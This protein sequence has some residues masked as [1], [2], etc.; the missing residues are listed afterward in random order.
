MRKLLYIFVT[1]IVLCNLSCKEDTEQLPLFDF[2]S[3]TFD[4]PFV[5][6]LSSRPE[7]LVKS[8]EYP[9]FSW[10][11]SDTVTF[12][13]DLE[14]EFNE[15]CIRSKSFV[16]LHIVDTLF[17]AYNGI[18]I[19]YNNQT[20]QNNSFTITADSLIKSGKINITISP[21]LKDTIL[22][23]FII[24]EGNAIDTANDVDLQNSN[25][26]IAT[27]TGKQKLGWP[28][29][30]WLI[31][32]FCV[33]AIIAIIA[34]FIFWLIKTILITKEIVSIPN[35]IDLERHRHVKQKYA[36]K[37]DKKKKDKKQ[38]TLREILLK[39][40]PD[41]VVVIDSLVEDIA[42]TSWD[43]FQGD[44]SKFRTIKLWSNSPYHSNWRIILKGSSVVI[45][46]GGVRNAKHYVNIVDTGYNEFLSYRM[47]NKKYLIDGYMNYKTD[48][49]GRVTNA[50]AKVSNDIIVWRGSRD[51]LHQNNIVVKQD[52]TPFLDEGG[53]IIQMAL[54]GCNELLNQIPQNAYVNK[55][56]YNKDLSDKENENNLFFKALERWELMKCCD[57]NKE[58]EIF[59]EFK[60]KRKCLRPYKIIANAKVVKGESAV[61]NDRKGP[62]IIPNP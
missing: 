22:T 61:L 3:E 37:K 48:R 45:A 6:I 8:L 58:I 15:D 33:I 31:W 52:G 62:F 27:W 30:I 25:N 29:L 57:E 13:K 10:L 59:R 4:E 56:H 5:G 36:K 39:K 16:T 12:T 17:N 42:C 40:Y 14:I 51:A 20:I 60:Y 21:E 19:K 24:A 1:G 41:I 11:M 7:I 23:G 43:E 46:E 38:K 28:I 55:G 54:G 50:H 44:F 47:P 18:S 53:H 35:F 26:V 32:L 49:L 9:P 2:G 34:Y